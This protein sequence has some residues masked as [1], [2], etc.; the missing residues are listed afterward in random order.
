MGNL[1]LRRRSS[2]D[3]FGISEDKP[4]MTDRPLRKIVGYEDRE[5]PLASGEVYVHQV[6]ILECGHRQG[7][8]QD[9]YG[10]TN[11]VRRRC[12]QCVETTAR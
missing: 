12:R 7:M 10:D 9:H 1:L 5:V 2:S 8:K 3:M 11:A 6:E 4:A